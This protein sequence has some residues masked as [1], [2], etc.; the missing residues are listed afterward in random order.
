MSLIRKPKRKAKPVKKKKREIEVRQM[1]LE[2]PSEVWHVGEKIFT[3]SYLP[4][5]YRTWNVDE[6]LSLFNG[7]PELCLVA[8]GVKSQDCGFC[9]GSDFETTSESVEIRLF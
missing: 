7:D 6:L 5:T 2:D 3:P 8:E 1:V 4:F 9:F